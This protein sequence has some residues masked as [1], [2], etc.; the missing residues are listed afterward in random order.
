MS[1]FPALD[2]LNFTAEKVIVNLKKYLEVLLCKISDKKTLCTLVPLV[3][4]HMNRE[5]LNLQQFLK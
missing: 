2:D 4:D 5:E 1:S 3:L